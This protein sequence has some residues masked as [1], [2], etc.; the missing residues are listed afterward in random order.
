MKA[1]IDARLSRLESANPAGRTFFLWEP[2][3][4][5]ELEALYRDRGIG[6]GDTV[7]LFRWMREPTETTN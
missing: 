1:G 4:E 3:T 7:Y 2:R 6:P 5:G